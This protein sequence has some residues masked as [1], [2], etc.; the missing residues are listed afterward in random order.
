MALT[1]H[2]ASGGLTTHSSGQPGV[3]LAHP[4]VAAGCRLIQALEPMTIPLLL[5]LQVALT[6]SPIV[7]G[8][9]NFQDL[10]EASCNPQGISDFEIA[11]CAHH[12]FLAEDKRLN[13]IYRELVSA[14]KGHRDPDMAMDIPD[15]SKLI[16][17]AQRAWLFVR[18][19]HCMAVGVNWS[20]G[21]GRAAA[22]FDC[23][24]TMTSQRANDLQLLLDNSK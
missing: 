16:I 6:N 19:N 5:M 3:D 1:V 18:D 21:N 10:A 9:E 17:E 13:S 24:A 4:T 20:G 11:T 8:V 14:T 2:H 22:E 23:M 12:R 7:Y 15:Q